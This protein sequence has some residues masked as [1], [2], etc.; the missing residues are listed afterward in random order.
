MA[1]LDREVLFDNERFIIGVLQVVSAGALIGAI[2]QFDTLWPLIGDKAF[3]AFLTI[4]LLALALAV[5]AAYAKH[6]YKVW[7]RKAANSRSKQETELAKKRSKKFGR[8]LKTMRYTI[9]AS[10]FLILTGFV[11][12][13]LSA[14][15]QAV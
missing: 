12:F 8:W 10:T 1:D 6:S 5:I 3:L 14:W 4:E 2:N 7:E 11:V 15:S 9:T 13:I